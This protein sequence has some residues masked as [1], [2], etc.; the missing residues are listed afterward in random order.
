MET[1]EFNSNSSHQPL[2]TNYY[3]FS[4]FSLL[5]HGLINSVVFFHTV[6]MGVFTLKPVII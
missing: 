3:S 6:N 5:E 2:I 1:S 4:Q